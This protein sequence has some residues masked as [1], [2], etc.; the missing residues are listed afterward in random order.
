MIDPSPCKPPP[1]AGP[2]AGAGAGTPAQP[3]TE[4]DGANGTGG[5]DGGG[6]GQHARTITRLFEEHNHALHAFLLMRLGGN[7]Q[8]AHDVAQEAYVRLLQLD[9]PGAVSLLRAYL[10][11]TA[12]NIAI[13]RARQRSTRMRL[14]QAETTL[15]DQ[16]NLLT[17]DRGLLAAEELQALENALLELPPRYR[18]AFLLHRFEDWPTQRIAGEFG[19]QE[20]MIRNYISRTAMYC[21]LRMQGLPAT[22]ARKQVMP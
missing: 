1:V 11:K 4:D 9:Q 12:A 8:D 17:P 6:P 22:A 19:T 7:A 14:D 18:Q 13:D 15:D 21:Q 5:E 2:Q 20:R 10:F 3:V 16:V